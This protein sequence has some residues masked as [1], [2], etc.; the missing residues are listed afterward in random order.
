MLQKLYCLIIIDSIALNK[1]WIKIFF[2]KNHWHLDFIQR[3]HNLTFIK[4]K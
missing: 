2:P 1:A 3:I 4:K